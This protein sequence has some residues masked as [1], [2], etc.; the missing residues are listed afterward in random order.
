[1]NTSQ[2]KALAALFFL[3]GFSIV[4]W[5]PRFPEV[6]HN[7]HLDN[8]QFGTL[9]SLGAI[10]SLLSLLTTGHLVH[11]LGTRK[12]LAGSAAIFLGSM[13]LI[14]HVTSTWQF[15]FCSI[16][17]GAGI[18]AFHI[19]VNSQ[20]FHEQAPT[21]E[22]LI[23]RMHGVWSVGALSAAVL[24][25][26]LTGKI[27][28]S[29]HIDVIA[30]VSFVTILILLKKFDTAFLPGVVG[31][32]SSYS[33][34]TLFSSFSVDWVIVF[35]LTGA[36]LLEFATGDWITI[37][38]KEE[39]HM[40]AGI[41]TVPYI[42]FILAMIIGRLSVH[43]VT[44]YVEI[45]KLLRLA[46]II[47]GATYMFSVTLGVQISRSFPM[48]GFLIVS[49]GIFVA[50]LGVSFLAPTFMDAANR[51]S[52]AP[53]SV[54]IGQLGVINT[55]VIFMLKSIIAWTA[56]LT[57]IGIA[58]MIPGLLFISVSFVASAIMKTRHV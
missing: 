31:S 27:P 36:A 32:N 10:G 38:T 19:S 58:L 17:L 9:I 12:T 8:G 45:V 21:G 26:F 53:G 16:A 42:L 37:F 51:R 50:G 29:V 7:L 47:G 25:G 22:N 5:V 49:V 41:S 28:L 44:K 23:P 52:Q 3:F 2:R 39:L 57:T 43:V 40:G 18:S 4:A 34:S 35:G 6:K 30:L 33:M 46:P 55:I 56:Q 54:V 20:A 48:I 15:L 1:M 24:S 14:V 11:G 13:A